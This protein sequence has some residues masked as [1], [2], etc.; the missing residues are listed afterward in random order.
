MNVQWEAAWQAV[1]HHP[2][3]GV[4]I[5]LAAFQLSYAAYEKTRWVF[6]QPVL[7][8]MLMVVGVLLACG[9]GYEDY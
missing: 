5:T 4:A 8:S 7:V 6:L 1:I 2:L 9:L 3:F